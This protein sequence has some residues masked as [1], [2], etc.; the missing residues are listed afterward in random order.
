[1]KWGEGISLV[2]ETQ[3]IE[4]LKEEVPGNQG[5]SIEGKTKRCKEF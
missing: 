5:R 2:L 4:N 3:N 1:M